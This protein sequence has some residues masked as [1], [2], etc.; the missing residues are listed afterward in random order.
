[1][2][3]MNSVRLILFVVKIILQSTN[4]QLTGK[5]TEMTEHEILAKG[6]AVASV[7]SVPSTDPTLWDVIDEDLPAYWVRRGQNSD[8]DFSKYARVYDKIKGVS[9][10]TR[11]VFFRKAISRDNCTTE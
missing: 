9:N 4:N 8:S 6:T 11:L 5:D 10:K 3:I 1:M 7:E 2:N